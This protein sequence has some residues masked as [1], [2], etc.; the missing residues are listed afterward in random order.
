MIA[1]TP[2][3]SRSD[4]RALFSFSSA[5]TASAFPDAIAEKML[6]AG[7]EAA[8]ASGTSGRRRRGARC[9]RRDR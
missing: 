2:F 7:P 1:E 8:A 6:T 9:D 3:S 4:E 5:S